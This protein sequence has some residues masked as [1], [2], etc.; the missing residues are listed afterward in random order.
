MTATA[1]EGQY[2]MVWGD[3]RIPDCQGRM[4]ASVENNLLV[5]V[6]DDDGTVV[7]RR[8]EP[9]TTPAYYPYPTAWQPKSGRS[10]TD[11]RFFPSREEWQAAVHEHRQRVERA[12]VWLQEERQKSWWRS[13]FG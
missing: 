12:K 6:L 9:L 8:L 2:F 11:W 5:D 13:L 1:F 10:T 3:G 7:E 4:V